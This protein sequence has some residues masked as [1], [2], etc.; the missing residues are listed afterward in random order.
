[1]DDIC[2]IN[3]FQTSAFSKGYSGK[4]AKDLTTTLFVCNMCQCFIRISFSF[5][6]AR[7][8]VTDNDIHCLSLR[9]FWVEQVAFNLTGQLSICILY[10]YIYIN[11]ENEDNKAELR[12]C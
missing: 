2:G 4:C 6:K 10:I 9:F 5:D 7:L 12:T 1:M 11:L 3:L 8:Y